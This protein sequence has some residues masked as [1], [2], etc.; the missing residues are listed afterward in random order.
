MKLSEWAKKQGISYRT[1]WRWFKEGNLPV[2]VEQMPNGTIL[3]KDTSTELNQ[4]VSS[5]TMID[6]C[7][8]D[9]NF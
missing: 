4:V 7:D 8:L 5:N 3:V 9:L 1:A 2:P 6:S